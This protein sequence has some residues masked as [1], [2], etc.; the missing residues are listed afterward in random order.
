MIDGRYVKHVVTTTLLRDELITDV[1][2]PTGATM[3]L[4][5]LLEIDLIH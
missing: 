1:F 4:H 3:M 2:T 5:T